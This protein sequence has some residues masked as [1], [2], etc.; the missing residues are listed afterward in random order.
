MTSDHGAFDS[1]AGGPR[2][3]PYCAYPRARDVA[4]HGLHV[5]P[6]FLPRVDFAQAHPYRSR[7]YTPI[8]AKRLAATQVLEMARVVATSFARREP[9]AR[10]LRPPKYPPAELLEAR[11]TD[12][13]GTEPLGPW[14]T[15]T[16]LYWFIRLLVLTD[17]A[18]PRSAIQVNREALA[19]SLAAVDRTGQVV[20]A[21]LNEPMP[22]LDVQPELRRDDPFLSA[23]LL[24]GEPVLT[25]LRT[26]NAVALTSISG[27]SGCVCPAQS[28]PPF[29]GGAL[30]RAR[31]SA[32]LRARGRHGGTLP[33]ARLRICGGR[34]DQS[35]ERS[36]V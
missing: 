14:I 20:G 24:F 9:M 26:Q 25:L 8:A 35:V 31:K 33:D 30:R 12:P 36:R 11:H 15:E 27:V 29:H 7:Q 21:A 28:R 34:G 32:H 18:S 19:Q 5:L 6:E 4:Q 16:L 3:L 2:S 23:V 13:F 10:H 17:P 22:P 1:A